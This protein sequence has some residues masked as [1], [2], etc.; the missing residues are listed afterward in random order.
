MLIPGPDTRVVELR[1]HG[2]LGTTPEDLV[3]AVAAVDVAGDGKGRLVRPADRLRRPA[4]G[5]VLKAEGR[6]LPRTVEG[7]VWG[8]LTSGGA[9]KAI[10]ALLFPFSLA[11]MASWMLPPVSEGRLGKTLAMCCR[12]LLRVGALLLT[13]LLI[14]QLASVSMDVFAAQ[15]LGPGSTCLGFLPGWVRTAATVRTIV[16]LLPILIVVA[17][18]HG[19]STVNWSVYAE[20]VTD[21]Q[22][23]PRLMSRLPGAGLI[24]DPDAPA[25]RTLHLTAA[26]ATTVLLAL[27]GPAGPIPSAAAAV[28]WGLAVA[29][30]VLSLVGVLVFGDPTG[31]RPDRYGKR[32]R[33]IL[34]AVPRRLAL[35]VNLG[36]I[37][38]VVAVRP[39][40]PNRLV[41]TDVTVEVVAIT[42]ACVCVLLALL[43]LPTA[44][45]ARK[46]WSDQPKPLRPWAGGWMAAPVLAI[47]A[48]LGGGFGS[49]IGLFVRTVLGD[50]ALVIPGGYAYITL[51]W[52]IAGVLGLVAAVIGGIVLAVRRALAKRGGRGMPAELPLLHAD[53][54]ADALSA[55]KAWWLAGW[56]RKSAPVVLLGLGIVVGLGAILAVLLR[57]EQVLPSSISTSNAIGTV[58]AMLAGFGVVVLA[59]LAGG[60]LTEVYQ[61]ARNPNSARKLGGFSDLAAFWP[62]EAHPIVP[63]CYAL[64]VVPELAARATEYLAEPSTRVVLT[65]HSQGSVL[66][67]VAASRLLATLPPQQAERL[68]IVVAGSPIQTAYVRAFPG[69]LGYAGLAEL[70]TDLGGRWRSLCR[71]TDPIGGGVTT[72]DR[73]VFHGQLI[74]VGLVPE[75]AAG[76][77]PAATVSPTGALV[78]GGDHWLP[79]PERGPF[80]GR[81][82]APGVHRHSDYYSDPEWDRAVACAAGMESPS[83]TTSQPALFRLPGRN[84][85]AG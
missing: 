67:A 64:K 1:V 75:A 44:L 65:G 48:T 57:N 50:S 63:P 12:A 79:D 85:A 18:L 22:A 81:R 6:P 76:A 62:R 32:L 80:P 58:A 72:W 13:M 53:R 40:L 49:G 69:V 70:F 51:L 46:Q 59:A 24:A 68:G 83:M 39:T 35:T 61:A 56:A 4:P 41:G 17:V 66:V 25:L 16:G 3:D 54:S 21:E 47:A 15:C 71:G 7:Y 73:Q 60:L 36:L 33:T 23:K 11:N 14:G 45:L 38:G 34:R 9:A 43:L 31:A 27:G 52:G 84:S 28:F 74:G 30:I 19:V 10:W 78:L 26:L 2:I 82:W 5:P 20:S 77:L 29:L 42:L 55:A 37:V 8:G